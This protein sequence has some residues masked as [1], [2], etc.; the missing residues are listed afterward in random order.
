[1]PEM[2][3]EN[4]SIRWSLRHIVVGVVAG[5]TIGVIGYWAQGYIWRPEVVF[6]VSERDT[7]FGPKLARDAALAMQR[8]LWREGM[9][10]MVTRLEGKV[11]ELGLQP[12][13]EERPDQAKQAEDSMDE[14]EAW[15]KTGELFSEL[16]DEVLRQNI[17]ASA[18]FPDKYVKVEVVNR[19]RKPAKDLR[20]ALK[21]PGNVVDCV[22]ECPSRPSIEYK[23]LT[24][25]DDIFQVGLEIPEEE[26]PTFVRGN[27]LTVEVWYGD[28]NLGQ[29][30]KEQH[31]EWPAERE[32]TV[33]HSGGLAAE[34]ISPLSEPQVVFV[35]PLI[36]VLV[37]LLPFLMVLILWRRFRTS[38]ARMEAIAD[39][40]E[41]TR[42]VGG[43]PNG[44]Q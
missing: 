13:D 27:R 9:Q 31:P 44:K 5:V 41:L 29:G 40:H 24:A 7:I 6:H 2:S 19:G 3:Q 26:I 22:V 36:G 42:E 25:I 28:P 16:Q 21:L 35:H 43:P 37:L 20:L 10:K 14:D 34:V 32:I 39:L 12:A 11:R 17:A 18:V 1:M 33:Q 15:R 23:R 4:H 30:A 38:P 8:T